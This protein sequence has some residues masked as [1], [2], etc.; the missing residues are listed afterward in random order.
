MTPREVFM[1]FVAGWLG[2]LGAVAAL[3]PHQVWPD[4]LFGAAEAVAAALWYVPGRRTFGFGA[5]LAILVVAMVRQL[6]AGQFPGVAIFYAAVVGY[7]AI[8][9]GA[10]KLGKG[11]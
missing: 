4:R 7:L 5:M 1:L 8:A 10:L 3:G 9:E 2:G 11:A 6:L